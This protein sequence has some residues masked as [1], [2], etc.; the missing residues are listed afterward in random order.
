MVHGGDPL[1]KAVS[2]QILMRSGVKYGEEALKSD[3]MNFERKHEDILKISKF[4]V[5]NAIKPHDN[6]ET[7]FEDRLRDVELGRRIAD[8]FDAFCMALFLNVKIEVF[9]KDIDNSLLVYSY[10]DDGAQRLTLSLLNDE[11]NYNYGIARVAKEDLDDNPF[12]Q[13]VKGRGERVLE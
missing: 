2:L 11:L 9:Y 4:Y 8:S 5:Q 1:F 13:F 6:E 12:I 3:L 7:S 10:N